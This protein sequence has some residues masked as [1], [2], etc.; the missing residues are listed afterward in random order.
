MH[1]FFVL[2]RAKNN[3]VYLGKQKKDNIPKNHDEY[4]QSPRLCYSNF[5]V[6]DFI[7][8]PH[9]LGG[10]ASSHILTLCKF[11]SRCSTSNPDYCPKSFTHVDDDVNFYKDT[12][13]LLIS[14]RAIRIIFDIVTS[15]SHSKNPEAFSR[16]DNQEVTE[17]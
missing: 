6:S 3:S 11:R 4:F 14:R 1:Q 15:H 12:T 5:F 7:S 13:Y 9:Y 8:I 17:D 10:S 16:D 2:L